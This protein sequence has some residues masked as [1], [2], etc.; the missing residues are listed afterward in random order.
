MNA[1][2]SYFFVQ[3][4]AW[5]FCMF[6]FTSYEDAASVHKVQQF[7]VANKILPATVLIV[8][9]LLFRY[10]LQK[11][12]LEKVFAR[13]KIIVFHLSSMLSPTQ[14]PSSQIVIGPARLK[15]QFSTAA[16][17]SQLGIS[18][19]SIS[20]PISRLSSFLSTCLCCF[21]SLCQVTGKSFFLATKINLS[22]R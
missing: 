8:T 2:N 21:Q 1:A 14:A 16:S 9:V 13:E 15:S 20:R 4:T 10:R 22:A 3:I 7:D 11:S 17:L 19:A 5:A 12:K 18:S 6:S